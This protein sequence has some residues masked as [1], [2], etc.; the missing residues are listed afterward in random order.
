MSEIII[1]PGQPSAGLLGLN[2]IGEG[3]VKASQ[4]SPTAPVVVTGSELDDNIDPVRPKS[5][6]VFQIGGNGGNDSFSGAG[7]NDSLTGGDGEDVIR[8]NG[9]NDTIDGGTGNDNLLGGAGNDTI[10]AGDGIDLV[11]GGTGNDQISGGQG[12]DTLMGGPGDD[13]ISGGEGNDTIIAGEGDDELFGG[14]GSDF[15][16][17]GSGNDILEGGSGRDIL[18]GGPGEDTFVFGPGSTGV[19]QLDRIIDF[20]PGED[21]IELSRALLPGS[22]LGNQLSEKNFAVV[23]DIGLGSTGSA[24]LIY[25]LKTG[26]VYYNAPGGKDVPLFQMQA[27]LNSLSASDFTIT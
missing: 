19:G 6:T 7:G 27:N 20:R 14:D 4:T 21:R 12:N 22:G 16:R 15:L 9:G 11:Y 18:K 2:I 25:E 24:T 1:N 3:I 17:G 26:I 8:G 10:Q 23:R 5:T 13:S